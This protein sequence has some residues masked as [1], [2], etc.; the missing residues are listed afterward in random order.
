MTEKLNEKEAEKIIIDLAKQGKT[1]ENIGLILKKEH[2]ILSKKNYGK[3]IS[4][5]L[6]ENNLYVNPDIKNIRENLEKLKKHISKNKGDKICRRA[7]MIKDAKLR[8]L[9]SL[10]SK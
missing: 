3:K 5:I 7:L 4:K 10:E 9:S 8:K 6:K 2:K 1:S